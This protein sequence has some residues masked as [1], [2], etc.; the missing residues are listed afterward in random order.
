MDGTLKNV[1]PKSDTNRDK[2]ILYHF[3]VSK[4]WY[5]FDS[6]GDVNQKLS[7]PCNSILNY[8]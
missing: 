7:L 2:K 5:D 1:F 4:L 3:Y 6:F 8:N